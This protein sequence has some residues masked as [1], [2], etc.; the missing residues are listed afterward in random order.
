MRPVRHKPPGRAQGEDNQ[1]PEN[2]LRLA[3]TGDSILMR[4]LNSRTDPV[5]QPLFDLIRGADIGFTNLEV[6]PN[7]HRGDPAQESGG[8]HF[9]APSW[10]VDEL[11]EAGFHLFAAATNHALDYSIS[12]LL[13]AIETLE[14]RGVAFA[15]VGRNLE[16]A[17]MPVYHTHPKATVAMLSCAS[18]FA[19][20]QQAG[21]QT[22][23]L[24]GRPG[25]NPLRYDTEHE[26]TAE[27]MATLRQMADQ[28]GLEKQRQA[29]IQL[30]FGFPPDDPAIFPLGEMNFREASRTAL[31]TSARK[32]DVDGIIRWLHETKP[33]SD[34]SLV[35]V[36]AHEQGTNA[37]GETD[38][39]VPAE[40]LPVFCR[41]MID[42]G[43][44]L[45]VGHGP[46]LLR[47]ME[48]YKGRPIF[49]SL[50]NFIGQ[51][52][53]VARLPS[54]S[55]ERFRVDPNTTPV[56]AYRQRTDHDRKGFPSDSRFWESVVPI[57][58]F[59]GNRLAGID[60]H[61]VS[62]GLG[63]AAHSRGR[64]R[65]AEGRH[66][67]DILGRFATLSASF[68]T[69]LDIRDGIAKVLLPGGRSA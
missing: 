27:Q 16:R 47:G 21:A 17:R 59:E 69:K 37:Q 35:S 9:A 43:A 32:K 61:P 25:R 22:A 41:R 64:P 34:L 42:E 33:V 11:V 62:L 66:A 51:N 46:H 18:T 7:D 3:L 53:L 26:I 54:D 45:V 50:G 4:R 12:G 49:Y 10:V 38:K 57:C 23:D 15:G 29:R 65:L 19:K 58:R 31:R 67:Q 36:H 1:V 8:S 28:L 55:Y 52:E 2:S 44:D 6:L 24:P 40:F 63:E 13:A 56:L 39:E 60:I 20:G 48:I 14:D 30:G 5:V 68:G